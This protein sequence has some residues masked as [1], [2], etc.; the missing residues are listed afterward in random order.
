MLI[1]LSVL[2]LSFR[3]KF[4]VVRVLLRE[5]KNIEF[6]TRQ[7]C[8]TNLVKE[9]LQRKEKQKSFFDI[10]NISLDTLVFE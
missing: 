9:Y 4:S 8:Q 2:V 3:P 10:V 7:N 1:T 5:K 6:F